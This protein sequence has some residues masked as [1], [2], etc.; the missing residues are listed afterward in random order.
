MARRQ[1]RKPSMGF[2]SLSFSMRSST[3]SSGAP[4]SAAMELTIESS[5]SPSGRNSC[6]GGSRRRIVTGRP[7]IALKMPSKSARWNT[8]MSSR[9]TLRLSVSAAMIILRTLRMRSSVLKNMCSVRTRPMPSAPFSRAVA[10]SSGVSALV[11]TFIVRF[12]STQLMK[13]SRS[14]DMAAGATGMAPS[15][16]LPVEPS[17]EMVSPSWYTLPPQES[18]RFCSSTTMSWAPQMHVLPQPRATTAAWDVMP[19]R[20]VRMPSAAA[21]PPTSSGDVSTRT[22]IA[23]LPAPLSS[24]ASSVENT[25]VP[26]AAPGD[27]GSPFAT[28]WDL[29]AEMSSNCGCSS[30]SR[31][32]GSTMLMACSLV[33]RPSSTMSQAIFTAALPV[34]LPARHCSMNSLPS[35]TVNSMSCMSL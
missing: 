35:C 19:P 29:N 7:S 12:S 34:R 26:T 30:W 15:Y 9:A 11:S 21:M 28:I 32:S 27:A 17:R 4:V 1:P 5:S 24:S 22:R 16:T 25:T 14:A 18:V 33:T 23:F 8:R 20:S 3:S 2:T 31:W 6:S 13:R 10:A